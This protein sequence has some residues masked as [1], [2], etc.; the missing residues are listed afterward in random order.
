M[1][2]RGRG[3]REDRRAAPADAVAELYV[4]AGLSAAEAGTLLHLPGSV[5]LRIAHDLGLPVRIDGPPPRRGAAASAGSTAPD[6][7][8]QVTV[9][10]PMAPRTN[11]R[12]WARSR[13]GV[14][15]GA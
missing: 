7:G 9:P 5:I 6:G 3:Y 15:L 8:W 10:A 4:H 14:T 12:G 11:V 1:R 2:S 13:P